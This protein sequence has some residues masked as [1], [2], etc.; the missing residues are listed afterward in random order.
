ME[1]QT[2]NLL[3][4]TLQYNHL[5]SNFTFIDAALKNINEQLLKLSISHDT[6]LKTNGKNRQDIH[7][8]LSKIK[9]Q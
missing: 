1:I 2:T 9:T 7:T 6:L 4:I 5:Q 3:G 8:I